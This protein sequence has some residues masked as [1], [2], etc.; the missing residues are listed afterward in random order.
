MPAEMEGFSVHTGDLSVI[1]P[2]VRAPMYGPAAENASR[3]ALEDPMPALST[4][5][6]AD[7]LRRRLDD[8]SLRIFDVSVVYSPAPP[9][10]VPTPLSG[11]E[12]WLVSHI[13]GAGF[14]DLVADL[15]DPE[16]GL[17]F[18]APS[19]GRFAEAVGRAGVGNDSSVVVYDRQGGAWA[20]RAWWLFRLFGHDDV[21]VLDGGWEAW[22]AAGGP[23]SAGPDS[24]P[25]RTFTPRL[26][27]ELLARSDDVLGALADPSTTVVDALPEDH[28]AGRV[29]GFPRAGHIAGALNLP[30]G[31]LVGEN[32][33]LRSPDELRDLAAAAG[34]PADGRIITYCG[35]GI[36][37]S[38]VALGLAAAGFGDVAVY[39]GSLAEWTADPALPMEL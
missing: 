37:A 38:A 35:G 8:P 5:I 29:A 26:R 25:P 20:A 23:V 15:S 32:G 27:A 34:L 14:L 3:R 22:T 17:P 18:T 31:K 39:D 12:D 2:H 19:E 7:R 11:R 6:G 28:Y 16:A 1:W 36:A 21:A 33:R 9:G 30:L 4:L 13:R 24:Y 10:G